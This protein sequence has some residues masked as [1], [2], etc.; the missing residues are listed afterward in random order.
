M[1]IWRPSLQVFPHPNYTVELANECEQNPI[2][3]FLPRSHTMTLLT[4]GRMFKPFLGESLL[5]C[6]ILI[7]RSYP[8]PPCRRPRVASYFPISCGSFSLFQSFCS[9]SC[10]RSIRFRRRGAL[11]AEV[12]RRT[13]LLGGS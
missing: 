1:S 13:S 10:Q 3:D 7:L 12:R 4:L 11:R 5:V 2:H 8:F 9:C 6:S